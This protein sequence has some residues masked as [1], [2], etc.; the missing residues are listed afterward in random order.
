M[1]KLRI[2][3]GGKESKESSEKIRLFSAYSV[4]DNFQGHDCVKLNWI[5]L[6]RRFPIARYD[7]LNGKGDHF[8]EG[9]P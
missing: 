7:R 4:V 5:H 1:V 2:I 3:N 6:E 8:S 9:I